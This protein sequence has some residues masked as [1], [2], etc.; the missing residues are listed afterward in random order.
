MNLIYSGLSAQTVTDLVIGVSGVISIVF[1]IVIL[2][3]GCY[4]LQSVIRLRRERTLF[5]N[6]VMYP[7]YCPY[8]ECIDPQGYV[9]VV[10]PKLT[11]LTAAMLLSGA[12]LILGYFIPALRT[13][14]ISLV[15]Y[16]AP[17]AVYMWYCACQRKAAKI[18]W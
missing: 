4:G 6:R 9:E 1:L 13:L 2:F 17:F 7:N 12:T 16:I 14:G 10:L 8:D 3:F 5:P 18:Y 11:V 15:V